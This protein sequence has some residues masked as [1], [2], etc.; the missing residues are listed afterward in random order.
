MYI[1]TSACIPTMEEKKG[2]DLQI[3]KHIKSIQSLYPSLLSENSAHMTRYYDVLHSVGLL[4]LL[5]R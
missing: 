3:L 5:A 1:I 4:N 2:T